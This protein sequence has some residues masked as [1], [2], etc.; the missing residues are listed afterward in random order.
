MCFPFTIHCVGHP[1]IDDAG[2]MALDAIE[3]PDRINAPQT[4]ESGR[5]LA[6]FSDCFGIRS[7]WSLF[8]LHRRL[9]LQREGHET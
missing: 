3:V 2:V 7:C 9:R 4:A 6:A 1:L 8:A 5:N